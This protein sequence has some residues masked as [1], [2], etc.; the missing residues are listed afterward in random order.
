MDYLTFIDDI[1]KIWSEEDNSK[2]CRDYSM[3]R[4]VLP[5]LMKLHREWTYSFDQLSNERDEIELQLNHFKSDVDLSNYVNLQKEL[6]DLRKE[7][8]DLKQDKEEYRKE[9]VIL[10]Q[11]NYNL[12]NSSI[13]KKIIG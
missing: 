8:N 6:N 4:S 13:F 2:I 10:K 3:N 9:I 11:D 7:L 12:R 1:D 5:A